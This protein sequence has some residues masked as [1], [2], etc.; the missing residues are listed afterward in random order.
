M[1]KYIKWELL[2]LVKK[3][4]KLMIGVA[5]LF[6]LALVMP[7]PEEADSWLLYFIYIP[8]AIAVFTFYFL[9][10]VLGT[11]KVVDT[12]RKKTFFLESM[13]AYSPSK[14]L[15][16]KY[17]IGIIINVFCV[18]VATIGTIIAITKLTNVEVL[19]E[20]F[21]AFINIGIGD[22][23][24]ITI[25][26]L[27]STVSFTSL[28]TFVYIVTKC[29]LPNKKGSFILGII[30]WW[31]INY[32]TSLV[33]DSIAPTSGILFFNSSTVDF[34]IFNLISIALIGIYYFVSV[35]LIE[36]KLEVYN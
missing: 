2:S 8:F 31:F 23:M 28:V 34:L 13:I 35:K 1:F 16:A 30:I 24:K 9:S 5:I 6:L 11:N 3:S 33:F 14:I 4:Y 20:V 12:F 32:F 36:H 10:F 19:M 7:L 27:V 25:T 21:N 26:F 15:F 29:I 22:F 17:L 18:I